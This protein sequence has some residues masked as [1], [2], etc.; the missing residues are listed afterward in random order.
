MSKKAVLS[1]FMVIT[2]ILSGALW[3]NEMATTD[4]GQRVRL[5]DDGTWQPAEEPELI[6]HFAG[7]ATKTTDTFSID[8]KPWRI[9]WQTDAVLF[10]VYINND[11]G[12]MVTLI[13]GPS[14]TSVIRETGA[15]YLDIL[16]AG[17]Y[18]IWITK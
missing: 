13:S 18:E 12:E 11:D 17:P 8:Q 3:A 15:F 14:D 1:F 10:Q 7:G 2:M 9:R 6:A 4:T 5:F 16:A